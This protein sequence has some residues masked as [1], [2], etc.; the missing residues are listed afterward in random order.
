MH[1]FMEKVE[2]LLIRSVILSLVLL[3]LVQGLMTQDPWRIYLS[4][5]ERMEGQNIEFP[6]STAQDEPISAREE[7]SVQS[8][9]A[10][11][12]LTLQEF[13][14]LPKAS[15]IVNG[16]TKGYFKEKEIKLQLSGGDVLE[17][18]STFYDFPVDYQISKVSQNM[19]FPKQG[20]LY[21]ANQ[22]I[23]MIGKIIVK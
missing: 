17:I 21:T 10:M 15:I 3:V 4:W 1:R 20:R 12:T 19:A 11:I 9:Q 16:K 23:V 7:A 5:G 13:S 18:D 2:R 14:S 8:P 22:S 6:A